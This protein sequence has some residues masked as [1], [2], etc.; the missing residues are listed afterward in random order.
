[1]SEA[2][3]IQ[4]IRNLEAERISLYNESQWKPESY[5]DTVDRRMNQIDEELKELKA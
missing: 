2:Q 3:R 4:K 1:M 5:Q